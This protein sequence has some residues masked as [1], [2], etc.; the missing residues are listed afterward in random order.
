MIYEREEYQ[1]AIVHFT[2]NLSRFYPHLVPT[3][4]HGSTVAQVIH[5]LDRVYPRMS[6]YLIDETGAPQGISFTRPIA[7]IVGR[8]WGTIFRQFI[9]CG[10]SKD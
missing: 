3:P 2:K 9:L 1:L 5:D 10:L 4:I 7:V 6:T 8:V